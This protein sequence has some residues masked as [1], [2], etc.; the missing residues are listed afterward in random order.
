M[1]AFFI[2]F[3]LIMIFLNYKIIVNKTLLKYNY[4][5]KVELRRIFS[6]LN[7]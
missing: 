5:I 2:S 3:K 6:I 1:L 7:L 4:I